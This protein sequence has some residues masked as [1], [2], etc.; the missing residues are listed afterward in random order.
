MSNENNLNEQKMGNITVSEDVVAAVVKNAVLE[1][2]GVKEIAGTQVEQK[3]LFF[4][5]IKENENGGI[6]VTI[7]EPDEAYIEIPVVLTYG[8]NV[9]DVSKNIQEKV[10]EA[11]AADVGMTAKDI[12]IIVEQIA[13]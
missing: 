13:D 10:K 11:V 8:T 12:D 7:K 5:T 3:F 4:K 2:E 6:K 1:I 9:I